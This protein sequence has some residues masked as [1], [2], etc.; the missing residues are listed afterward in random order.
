MLTWFHR[1]WPAN[2][3]A[4][5]DRWGSGYHN[6]VPELPDVDRFRANLAERAEGRTIQRVDVLDAGVLHGIA[7]RT[8][9]DALTG[10]RWRSPERHGKWLLAHTDGPTVLV[11]F[12]M[13]GDLRWSPAD[14]PRDRFDRVVFV[15]DDGELRYRDMR[16][17]QGLQLAPDAGAVEKAMA[18]LGPDA[19]A[20]RRGDFDELLAGH[21]GAVKAVLVDQSILAG[22]GNLL[23]D[24]ILWHAKIHPQ[25]LAHQ[26]S[27]EQRHQ[28]YDEMRG[29]LRASIRAGRIPDGPGWLTGLRDDPDAR[30]PRC[31]T[32]LSRRRVGGR[33]TI[34]CPDC[35]RAPR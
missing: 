29:V 17:L 8:L 2:P 16:K 22:L 25:Q 19:L 4:V 3:P 6:P 12:G 27:P 1:W 34:W 28:L 24:E 10:H 11:H 20:V 7:A 32:P 15:L 26:L 30:C 18:G 13:T 14:E 21:R 23:A 5:V 35:Q 31:G 9:D 33:A